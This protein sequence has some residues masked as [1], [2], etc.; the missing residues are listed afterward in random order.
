[1]WQGGNAKACENVQL[2]TQR[3]TPDD[4]REGQGVCEIWGFIQDQVDLQRTVVMRNIG[5]VAPWPAR[6]EIDV[7]I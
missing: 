5:G 1:M 3:T 2:V 6:R 7:R 4:A